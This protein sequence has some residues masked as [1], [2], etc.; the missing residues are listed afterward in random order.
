MQQSNI[1]P[2]CKL[3]AAVLYFLTDRHYRTASDTA[4]DGPVYLAQPP[5]RP[6][7]PAIPLVHPADGVS[8]P[9]KAL[10][11]FDTRCSRHRLVPVE[12]TAV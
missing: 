1:G 8:P 12:R 6:S 3:E 10:S 4:K 7:V 2:F 9:S 11:S 5:P